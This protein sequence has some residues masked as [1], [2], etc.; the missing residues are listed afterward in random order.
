[1]AGLVGD[2]HR[3]QGI[4]FF[5]S[6]GLWACLISKIGGYHWKKIWIFAGLAV[7]LETFIVW[8]EWAGRIVILGTLGNPNLLAGYLAA[9]LPVVILNLKN[10]SLIRLFWLVTTPFLIGAVILTGSRVGVLMLV[11]ES[12]VIFVYGLKTAKKYF[13]LF[14]AVVLLL[15]LGIGATWQ[16][17]DQSLFEN[18]WLIWKL[19]IAAIARQP[20]LGYGPEGTTL[21]YDRAFKSMDYRLED[22]IIDRAHN[23]F[24]DIT[25]SSG[26][27]GLFFFLLWLAEA[28]KQAA[29]SPYKLAGFMGIIVFAF[30]QPLGVVHWFYLIFFA[31]SSSSFR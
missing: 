27:S 28:L 19:G 18:R 26:V 13:F 3:H 15:L 5:L 11:I 23:I 6:L 2:Q 22:L 21:A 7:L 10:S 25:L 12:L 20:L 30:F 29:G 16:E 4:V 1:M 24:I 17:K 9:G 31:T 14:I 8:S